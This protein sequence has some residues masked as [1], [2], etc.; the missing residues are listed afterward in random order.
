M[1]G[2]A[3]CE[4]AVSTSRTACGLADCTRTSVHTQGLSSCSN[5]FGYFGRSLNTIFST[6]GIGMA[7]FSERGATSSSFPCFLNSVQVHE[8][9][10]SFAGRKLSISTM[11]CAASPIH[12]SSFLPISPVEHG[13][14]W[15]PI[16]REPSASFP[17]CTF[18]SQAQTW[19][20]F[21]PDVASVSPHQTKA[22]SRNRSFSQAGF[23]LSGGYTETTRHLIPEIVRPTAIILPV[24]LHF[25]LSYPVSLQARR[26]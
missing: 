25:H 20:S 15:V 19:I 9:T 12:P 4:A 13:R 23:V 7:A 8:L 10:L 22:F 2:C 18:Q 16:P 26:S 11:S 14:R 21:R 6:S 17:I 24:S 3:A 5:G 1:K